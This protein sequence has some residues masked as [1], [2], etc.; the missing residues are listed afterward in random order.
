[1]KKLIIL[2]LTAVLFCVSPAIATD[3]YVA[4]NGSDGNP[5]TL[6]EPWE[7]LQY[8]VDSISGGDTVYLRGGVYTEGA[9]AFLMSDVNGT[10]QNYTTITNYQDEEPILEACF[11][12]TGWSL[13]SDSIYV[14]SWDAG[15]Q[16]ASGGDG[17]T[18][19]SSG[20]VN[21]DKT[22][23][24]DNWL[25][26]FEELVDIEAGGWHY[27]QG[28]NLLYVWL[29]DSS[30]PSGHNIYSVG[31][32]WWS[33]LPIALN[34][35]S[36]LRVENITV[37]LAQFAI[38]NSNSPTTHDVIFDNMKIYGVRAGFVP[39][40][41]AINMTLQ[42]SEIYNTQGPGVQCNADYN[43]IQNNKIYDI[44]ALQLD[45]P[46]GKAWGGCSVTVLGSYNTI[47]KNEIYDGKSDGINLEAWGINGPGQET[48]HDN[49]VEYNYIYRTGADAATGISSIGADY[50]I[51]RN[52]II[53]NYAT[54]ISTQI[55]GLA[56]GMGTYPDQRIT[57][58]NKIYN[59]TIVSCDTAGIALTE[60]GYLENVEVKNNIVYE[61]GYNIYISHTDLMN[62][63]TID[64]NL[65]KLTP[66]TGNFRSGDG[67][68]HFSLASWQVELDGYST[69]AGDDHSIEGDPIFKDI[70]NLDFSLDSNSPAI[71]AG[72]DLGAS[73]D[74]ALNP[75]STWP[76]SVTTLDQDDYGTWEIG[77]YVY[78]L[79]GP[80][81]GPGTIAGGGTGTITGGGTGTI[82]GTEP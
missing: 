82:E 27:D 14:A 75:N 51:I 31:D 80:V 4:S 47:T 68:N 61:S 28:N 12:V 6:A 29:Q 35:V 40:W 2:I 44:S 43:T 71:N 39:E 10:A 79:A 15:T 55:G 41:P 53:Y 59:N 30:N 11:E 76:S 20:F 58:Y 77:A 42:N 57:K 33:M 60:S 38:T 22:F 21:V 34:R 56:E 81:G 78:V 73:Y 32:T 72:L 16:L 25:E 26:P 8:A 64:Y 69:P 46:Y 66:T 74:D 7:T 3:Y 9:G 17:Y 54:G 48:G 70:G 52:N 65:Y 13:Y 36:Y 45:W 37:R 63:I 49:V 5:G 24:T 1:M 23:D 19:K 50:T 18:V 62:D 67:S